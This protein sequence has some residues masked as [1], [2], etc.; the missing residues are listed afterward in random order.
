MKLSMIWAEDEGGCIGKDNTMPWGRLP[1]DM[2][3]FRKHT[4]GKAIIMGRKT[5]DTLPGPLKRRQNIVLTRQ[6]SF[7]AHPDVMVACNPA[8]ALRT[9]LGWDEVVIIGGAQVYQIFLEKVTTLYRTTVH[10]R[11]DGD[12][13]FPKTPNWS[14]NQHTRTFHER[15]EAD[16][17]NA[18]DLTFEIFH[19]GRLGHEKSS[20]VLFK[21]DPSTNGPR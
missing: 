5:Y 14:P 12:T 20:S 21:E 19:Q 7:K 4:M 8:K 17:A 18:W 2:K 16:L 13:F 1:A 11:F 15:R 10:H 3:W 9:A 6:E